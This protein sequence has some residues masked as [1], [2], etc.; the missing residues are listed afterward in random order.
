MSIL[1]PPSSRLPPPSV[2]RISHSVSVENFDNYQGEEEGREGEGEEGGQEE[3]M[4]DF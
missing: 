1:N 2:P 3:W 4:D